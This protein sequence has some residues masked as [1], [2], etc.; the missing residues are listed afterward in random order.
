LDEIENSPD[1]TEEQKQ[2][3]RVA[4]ETLY[5]IMNNF[6]SEG[7]PLF[8]RCASGILDYYAGLTCFA[9]LADWDT[10]LSQN[11]SNHVLTLSTGTCD[12]VKAD[13]IDFFVLIRD[14]AVRLAE[15][16]AGVPGAGTGTTLSD[17]CSGDCGAFICSSLVAGTDLSSEATPNKR[18]VE[19]SVA[20]GSPLLSEKLSIHLNGFVD[21]VHDVLNK[22][23]AVHFQM[24]QKLDKRQG[25][26]TSNA[27]ADNGYPA[28][29]NGAVAGFNT[30][31]EGGSATALSNWLSVLF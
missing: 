23:A 26:S 22:G 1:L 28:Y 16:L 15:A 19:Y 7:I 2:Q 30:E 21:S 9:C 11:G 3:V 6:F 29:E 13:C 5:D 25:S 18:T 14:L 8:A 24:K 12:G 17:I 27:Y 10:Y 4:F 31:I 20:V